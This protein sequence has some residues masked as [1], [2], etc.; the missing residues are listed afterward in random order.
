VERG[1][2]QEREKRERTRKVTMK[3]ESKEENN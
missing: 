2:G 3:R 1:E